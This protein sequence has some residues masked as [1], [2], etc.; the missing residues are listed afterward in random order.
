MRPFQAAVQ[1]MSSSNLAI[2]VSKVSGDQRVSKADSV[3]VEEP[4]EIQL[5][6]ASAEGAAAKSVSITMRTPDDD[7]E[8][9]VGFLYTEGIIQS[10]D[11]V[12]FVEHCG[13]LTDDSGLRNII[14]VTCKPDVEVDLG[15]LHAATVFKSGRRNTI[16]QNWIGYYNEQQL[17]SKLE[18]LTLSEVYA[19]IRPLSLAS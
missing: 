7:A 6:S 10:D 9:A 8:L 3:A 15:G 12:A 1:T 2:D 13:A 14:R 16:C 19:G 4:L 11:H 17:H 18:Y 5:G